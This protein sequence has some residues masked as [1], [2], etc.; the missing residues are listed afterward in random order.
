MKM[1]SPIKLYGGTPGTAPPYLAVK[2]ICMD[3]VTKDIKVNRLTKTN[4]TKTIDVDEFIKN[5]FVRF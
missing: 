2:K 5:F 1:I 4:C 3:L